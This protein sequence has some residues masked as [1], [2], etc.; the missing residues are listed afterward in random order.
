MTAAT[1]TVPAPADTT[2]CPAHRLD[3]D[4]DVAIDQLPPITPR[5]REILR[6]LN[7]IWDADEDAVTACQGSVE[8]TGA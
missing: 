2:P 3:G 1:I 7:E 4:P 8:I 5:G 6:V